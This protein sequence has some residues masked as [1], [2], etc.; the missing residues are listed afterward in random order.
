MGLKIIWLLQSRRFW[1]SVGG[2]LA[3]V[4]GESFGMSEDQVNQVVAIVI[5]WCIGDSV[6][7]TGFHNIE[8]KDK[9]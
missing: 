2:V 1:A 3:V 5:G 7:P 9:R 6:K 4:A 8:W